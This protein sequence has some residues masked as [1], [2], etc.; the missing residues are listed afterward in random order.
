MILQ[1]KSKCIYYEASLTRRSQTCEGAYETLTLARESVAYTGFSVHGLIPLLSAVTVGVPAYDCV[2]AN[3]SAQ[4]ALA[5][6]WAEL[7]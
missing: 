3:D 7:I 4:T 5:H 1:Q 2:K 6:V